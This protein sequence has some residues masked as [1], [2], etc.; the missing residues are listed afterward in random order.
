MNRREFLKTAGLAA[1][2]IALPIGVVG[3][4]PHFDPNNQYGNYLEFTGLACDDMLREIANEFTEEIKLVIPRKYR[5]RIEYN[6]VKPSATP[7]DPFAVR[8]F[9]AWKYTPSKRVL[10]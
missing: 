8:G 9:A 6:L 7:S 2:A 5:N 1:A 4:Y 10:A 3:D